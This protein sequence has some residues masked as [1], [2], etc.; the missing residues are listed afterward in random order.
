[1]DTRN[2]ERHLT[3]FSQKRVDQQ[4]ENDEKVEEEN[5]EKVDEENPEDCVDED[6]E[7]KDWKHA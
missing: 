1:L 6:L 5:H 4:K 7:E 2:L 3:T